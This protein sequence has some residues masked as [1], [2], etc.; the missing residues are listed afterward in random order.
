MKKGFTLIEL[1]AVIIVLAIIALIATPIILNII[2]SS[3]ES[4]NSISINNYIKAIENSI[5][6][7]EMHNE[8]ILD[9]TYEITLDGNICLSE[10]KDSFCSDILKIEIDGTRP[11]SGYI[12]IKGK[13]VDNFYD[14]KFQD[15]YVSMD[16][17]GNLVFKNTLDKACELVVVSTST[18]YNSSNLLSIGSK[19]NCQGENFYVIEYDEL[20]VT[21]LTEKNITIDENNPVQSDD[22]ATTPFSNLNYWGN[23]TLTEYKPF[24][25]NENSLVYKYVNAYENKLKNM[26]I[27]SAKASIPSENQ[28]NNLGLYD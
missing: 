19:I 24:V 1:L 10:Y 9:G 11:T 22:A 16:E 4:S 23:I 2:D 25:Y 8:I 5:A 28:I 18:S 6:L 17:D 3:R 13:R 7:K 27:N 12:K 26:G 20:S 14:V 15:F 21:M